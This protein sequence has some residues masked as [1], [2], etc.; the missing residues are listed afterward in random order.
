MSLYAATKKSNEMMAHCYS[1]LFSLPTKGLRFFTVYGPWGRP[2]MALFIFTRKIL[3]GEPIDVFNHGRHRR[4][5]TYVD[6]I[7]EGVKR[8]LDQAAQPN[9]SWD[10]M[11]PDPATSHAPYRIYNIGNNNWV[12]LIRYIEVIEQCLG[13]SVHKNLLPLQPGDVP[14]TYADVDDL[15]RDLDYKPSTSVEVGI[16][17]F[18]Q[19]YQEYYGH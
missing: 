10:P 16:E 17:R 12:E 3:A 1:H 11:Q 2:D 18:L 19:W 5:F 4:D 6:D 13:K 7:V 8:V 14:D 15:V 9:E